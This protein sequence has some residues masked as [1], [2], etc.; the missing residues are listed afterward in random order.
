MSLSTLRSKGPRNA[1]TLKKK[2][3][4]IKAARN[5]PNYGVRKLA[6]LFECGRTQISTILKEKDAILELYEA[7]QA[8][9]SFS[10]RKRRRPCEFSGINEALHEW[11]LMA[12]SKNVYPVG[13]QLCEKAK[14]IAERLEVGN[15]KASNG[16]LDRWKKRYN[17]RHV[18]INGESGEVSGLTVES[19]KERLPELLHDF[20]SR[21]IWNIDET[22]CF[23]KTLPDHGFARKGS[24][25]RGGKKAKQR[26]T[27][28]LI[29]NAVGDKEA[30]VVIWKYA[31]PRCFKSIDMD[32]LPVHYFSQPK[33]WMTAD[34]LEMILSKLNRRLSSQHRKI[35]LLM[36]NAGCHPG[37]C[38]IDRF[39]NIRVIFL[40]PNT[41]SKLQ[42]LDLGIIQNFKVHYRTLFLRFLLSKIDTCET[43]SEIS[44]SVT[45]LQAIRWIAQAWN[46][47]KPDTIH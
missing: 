35:A 27:I 43:A 39:S 3:D 20:A 46:A 14:Q 11:Y 7:N 47:V 1:L 29:T 40:P 19:W 45:I 2:V 6:D 22:G 38:L 37:S 32:S 8:S 15:F 4:V 42:P 23:W 36:D 16:W 26:V 9:E 17:I 18:K 33:A 28:A 31:K 5:N 21:D 24:Q 10:S 12:C 30:A 41:T 25:C 44:N 13:P 34:I